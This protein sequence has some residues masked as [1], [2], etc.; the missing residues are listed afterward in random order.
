[1]TLPGTIVADR[2]GRRRR[3]P[4]TDTGTAFWVVVTERSPLGPV[5][6]DSFDD[7]TR[8]T[9][10]RVTWSA[11]YDDA[12][13]FFADGGATLYVSPS[14]GPA[15]AA[16]TAT[17]Q[18]AGA[19]A[20][21]VATSLGRDL[22]SNRL[23]IRAYAPVT[24]GYQLG[25]LL[26]GV[27]VER[28]LD[29][30]D[31]QAGV[32]WAK[33]SAYLRLARGAG[34]GNPAPAAAVALTGGTDDHANVND[35]SN[36]AALD[37]F[38]FN[39]GPGQVTMPR[40]TTPT[41]H[42][43]IAAHC[44]ANGRHGY[45]DVPDSPSLSTVLGA[46]TALLTLPI[47]QRRSIDLI[48][49]WGIGPGLIPGQ[50]LPV[51][52]AALQC[53]HAARND[54]V[55]S[56]NNALAGDNGWTDYLSDLKYHRTDA[57]R[58]QLNDAGINVAI[59]KDGL[60]EMYGNRTMTDK[61]TDPL[62]IEASGARE[63]M[64]IRTLARAIGDKYVHHVVD[65]RGHVMG[66]FKGELNAMLDGEWKTDGLYGLTAADAWRVDVG[67]TVNTPATRLAKQLV[68]DLYLKLAWNAEQVKITIVNSD[69][70]AA[71]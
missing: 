59:I 61:A 14:V 12:Q 8:L 66:E 33:N 23:S 41:S 58:A 21:L 57:D 32:D 52:G 13:A 1:M 48:D 27:E 45:G 42:G 44:L 4:H 55:Q 64:R 20:S 16:A 68:A 34:T 10:G 36:Q 24:A 6:C 37:L 51:S 18:T 3:S 25:V 65:G 15:A 50:T 53:A 46:G 71:L 17:L 60:I 62:Y 38:T 22:Y 35:A 63:L 70:E 7:F 39:L 69:L 2:G 19:T 31:Q 54:A 26:D 40:R 9:G 29:L 28:S 11:D 30:A 43:Q 49:M 56:P 47:L 67:P 5:K